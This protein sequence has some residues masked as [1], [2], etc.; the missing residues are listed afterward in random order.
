MV[1]VDSHTLVSNIQVM[2]APLCTHSLP[3]DLLNVQILIPA[4]AQAP[5]MHARAV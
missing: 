5:H 2:D 4:F 3:C 1:F